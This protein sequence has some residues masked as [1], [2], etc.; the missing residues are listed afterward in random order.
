MVANFPGDTN[1]V[2]KC[3]FLTKIRGYRAF[4]VQYNGQC[5]TAF[6]A[7]ETYRKYG[8]SN[9]CANTGRGGNWANEVYFLREYMIGV[10]NK[11]TTTMYVV[12]FYK[13]L[14]SKEVGREKI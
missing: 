3:A 9:A 10:N 6:N 14:K 4:G 5:F 1:A 7:H 11:K 8:P 2:A 12:V 13:Q